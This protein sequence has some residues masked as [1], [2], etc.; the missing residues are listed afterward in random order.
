VSPSDLRV[1]DCIARVPTGERVTRVALAP[2]GNDHAGEVFASFT[3]PAGRFPG[4]DEVTR[5]AFAGCT[6]RYPSLSATG[7]FF[8]S[9]KTA[10]LWSAR[11]RV[12]CL[13]VG[14]DPTGAKPA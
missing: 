13:A 11:R 2:C 10:A 6:R 9:P 5:L 8:L 3:L 7:L 12:V 1:G 14:S 4:A